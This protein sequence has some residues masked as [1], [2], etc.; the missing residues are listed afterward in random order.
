MRIWLVWLLLALPLLAVPVDRYESSIAAFEAA[1]RLK[2]TEAGGTLFLGS[3]TFTLWGHDLEREFARFHALNR[4]FGGSTIPE[5]DHYLE[6]ICFPY[7][8]RLVVF[9][10]GTNDVAEGH[11]PQQIADD[12]EH[13]LAHLRRQLPNTRVAYVSMAVPPSRLQFS[14]QYKEANRKLKQFCKD[15]NNLDFVDVSQ[16]LLD[17]QGQPKPEYYRE[18]QLHMKPSGYALWIPVLRDYLEGVNN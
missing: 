3:S 7:K 16:L 9:Y 10:V 1:D 12:F 2:T 8:P 6:R 11:S 17:G 5:V 14:S 13:L 15:E 18:D 4:G